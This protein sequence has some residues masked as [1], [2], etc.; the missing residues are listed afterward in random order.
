[1]TLAY[2]VMREGGV[3]A[4]VDGTVVDL[5]PLDPLFDACR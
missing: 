5:R 3:C 2:G 1:M 4:R